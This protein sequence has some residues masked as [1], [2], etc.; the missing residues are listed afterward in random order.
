VLHLAAIAH[1][2]GIPYDLNNVNAISQKVP[3]LCKLAPAGGHH[4]QDLDLAGGV[5]AVMKE[6]YD[7]GYLEGGLMTV[8]GK[9][10]AENVSSASVKNRDV[11]RS[12]QAPYANTG[13]IAI[14]FGNLAPNGSVVKRSAV[15][16]EMLVHKGPA[17]VFDSEDAAS[18]AIFG[19]DVKPGDVLVIRYE[20]PAGG[21]G[22]REMLAPTSAIAGMGLDNCVALIT[23]GRFSGA[24]RGA[25]IG[26]VSPEAAAGGPIAYVVEGDTIS[27]DIPNHKLELLVSDEDLAGRKKT[28]PIKVNPVSGYLKRYAARVSSA[29]KGAIIE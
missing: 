26:H 17:R 24:T 4:M 8:T 9:T 14:L 21:P 19:G 2:A 15:N 10:V 27:I 18:K 13:G 28:M 12:I 29:E 3:N 7:G 6:L 11:I 25:S 20:G 23:D 5:H 16:P 1:E 22:M